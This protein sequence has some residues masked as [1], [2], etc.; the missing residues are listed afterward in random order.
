M[1]THKHKPQSH[2]NIISIFLL[3]LLLCPLLSAGQHIL[4]YQGQ[5]SG[6][7]GYNP[8]L[9]QPLWLGMRYI[10]QINLQLG[11]Q[12]GEAW[13]FEAS[14]NLNASLEAKG[15]S[16][17]STDGRFK[18][19]RAWA[20]YA[21][22]QYELRLGLQKINFGSATLLRPLMWFDQVDARD[23]L[24]LTDGVWALLGRYY[25]LN[26]ANIWLWGLYG[27][28]DPKTWEQGQTTA[29]KPEFG[30]RIQSPIPRGEAALSF[31]HR[32]VDTR[33]F[34]PLLP[35]HKA[36]PESRIGFDAK[37]DITIGL[38]LEAT[39]THKH[40]NMGILTNQQLLNLGADYTFA[41]GNGLNLLAEHLFLSMGQKP[42]ESQENIH[43]S[44]LS[45]NY[46]LGL[47]D[48]LNAILYYDWYNQQT[49]S[50]AHWHRQFNRL[51]FYLMAFWNPSRFDLPQQQN[52]SQRFA[53]KGF[54]FM[55]VYNH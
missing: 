19:Y 49:Y 3:G 50:F 8:E 31:H 33:P 20:R 32:Q 16:D 40:E 55:L 5:A 9:T 44:A 12:S 4:K 39:W 6:W 37:W 30:A 46:P 7:S 27:N 10:P 26:N 43:F 51:G 11:S 2:R 18:P 22:N 1:P 36:L 13:D 52:Q 45:I 41:W 29:R 42:F 24:Q 15:F 17:L 21:G 34:Q 47:F 25:F 48:N 53:G 54:Q 38:W 23:P 35:A 28:E 14:A